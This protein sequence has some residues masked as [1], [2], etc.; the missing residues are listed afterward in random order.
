L[1]KELM[2]KGPKHEPILWEALWKKPK[3][4]GEKE[5]RSNPRARSAKMRSAIKREAG[6][7]VR[8]ESEQDV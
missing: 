1:V 2:R 8:P 7:E 5:L 6:R 3:G 4:P